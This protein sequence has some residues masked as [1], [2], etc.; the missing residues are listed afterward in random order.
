[1]LAR[2]VEQ[3][4]TRRT[5]QAVVADL[6]EPLGQHVLQEAAEGVPLDETG[7]PPITE[8][9]LA[10]LKPFERLTIARKT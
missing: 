10:V 3:V 5:E 6:G 8:G 4:A 7:Q 1:L 9:H 2:L